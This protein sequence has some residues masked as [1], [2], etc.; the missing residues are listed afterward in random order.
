MCMPSLV[1]VIEL[2][3]NALYDFYKVSTVVKRIKL[4]IKT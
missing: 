3:D 1:S 4:I 2:L